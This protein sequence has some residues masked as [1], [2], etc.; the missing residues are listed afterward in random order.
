MFSILFSEQK[1]QNEKEK[2]FFN[3]QVKR[4]LHTTCKRIGKTKDKHSMP[5]NILK[6]TLNRPCAT[7]NHKD[8]QTLGKNK[9]L[10][11]PVSVLRNPLRLQFISDYCYT[12]Q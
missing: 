11:N 7:E 8:P 4:I 1:Q 10:K 2:Y 5:P 6:K 3:V 9:P 12:L